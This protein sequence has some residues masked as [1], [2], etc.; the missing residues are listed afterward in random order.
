MADPVGLD[1]WRIE[2][3]PTMI[4]ATATLACGIGLLDQQ[5]VRGV[6]WN[7]LPSGL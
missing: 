4:V 1:F 6:M 5:P 3:Y 2:G 7:D